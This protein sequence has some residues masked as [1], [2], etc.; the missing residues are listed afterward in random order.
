MLLFYSENTVQQ[1]EVSYHIYSFDTLTPLL[2]DWWSCDRYREGRLA[3]TPIAFSPTSTLKDDNPWNN[4]HVKKIKL[5]L[6]YKDYKTST[7]NLY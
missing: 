6:I 3:A 5:Y 7:Y 2:A 1:Q 4:I